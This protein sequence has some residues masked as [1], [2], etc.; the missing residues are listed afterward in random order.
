MDYLEIEKILKEKVKQE[1]LNFKVEFSEAFIFDLKELIKNSK[2]TKNEIEHILQD[3]LKKDEYFLSTKEKYLNILDKKE[4]RIQFKFDENNRLLKFEYFD[5]LVAVKEVYGML[6]SLDFLNEIIFTLLVYYEFIFN[7][8]DISNIQD[9]F[10][11]QNIWKNLYFLLF[12]GVLILLYIKEG[13]DEREGKKKSIWG[14]KNLFDKIRK[15]LRSGEN[16]DSSRFFFL[17]RWL[18]IWILCMVQISGE[19]N[20][21]CYMILNIICVLLWMGYS[22][23]HLLK[24]FNM[25]IQMILIFSIFIGIIGLFNTND[26]EFIILISVIINIMFSEDVLYLVNGLSFKK[27]TKKKEKSQNKTTEIKLKLKLNLILAIIYIFV[28]FTNRSLIF[29]PLLNKLINTAKET[30][31][32]IQIFYIGTERVIILAFLT[33]VFKSKNKHLKN[34][35]KEFIENY[36][37]VLKYIAIKLYG[38]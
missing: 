24:V 20:D 19:N 13:K 9:I 6:N 31:E 3:V 11:I 35:K 2:I 22:L 34:L 21:I 7:I 23:K 38:E 18:N 27:K 29:Q 26:W 1:T 10:K 33:I 32:I 14:S 17:V 4:I 25:N 8:Q 30:S 37:S 28:K 12:L 36:Q 15:W 5:C 16:L